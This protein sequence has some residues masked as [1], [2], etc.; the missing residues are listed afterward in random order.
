MLQPES[1]KIRA[2]CP[3]IIPRISGG[4]VASGSARMS[5]HPSNKGVSDDTSGF[6]E[7]EGG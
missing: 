7:V 1:N 3:C 2:G 6:V 5:R 4:S